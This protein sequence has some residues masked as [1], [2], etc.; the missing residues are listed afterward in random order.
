MLLV[1]KA[2]EQST[3]IDHEVKTLKVG[4]GYDVEKELE[5]HQCKDVFILQTHV[6]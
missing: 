1:D 3:S 5:M 6:N 2:E 4:D